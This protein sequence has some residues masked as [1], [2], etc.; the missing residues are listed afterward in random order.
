[1]SCIPTV[2]VFL[3]FFLALPLAAQCTYFL[4][5]NFQGVAKSG[6][7]LS[8]SLNTQSGCAWT[9]TTA[10]SWIS[11]TSATS[12][13]GS[14][15]V[16]YT[17]AANPNPTFRNGSLLIAGIRFA[18][19]QAGDETIG[20]LAGGYM[21]DGGQALQAALYD[22]SQV[23]VD[24]AG[25][26]YIADSGAYRVRKVTPGGVIT[27]I[28]GDGYS[29]FSGDGGLATSARFEQVGAIAVDA[30]GNIYVADRYRIR[31]ITPA[32]MISTYAGTGQR[33]YSGDGGQATAAQIS[34][35][36]GLAVSPAGELHIGDRENNRVRKVS[37]GGVI[38]TVAGNGLP[39]YF[40]PDEGALATS[41]GLYAPVG[42]AFDSLGRM[43]I[44]ESLGH[45]IRRVS[46]GTI[47]TLAGN[48][49]SG[50][51]G[52][53]GPGLSA[54]LSGPEGIAVDS[55]GSVYFSDNGTLIRKLTAAGIISTFTGQDGFLGDS[56]DG[57]PAA[58]AYLGYTHG[59]AVGPAD[60]IYVADGWNQ[61]V[62]VVD[63]SGNI[64]TVAGPGGYAGEG[65]PGSGATLSYP[66][67]IAVDGAGSAY[68][69]QCRFERVLKVSAAGV[70]TT[71]AGTGVNGF[72]GDGAP[73]TAARFS[74]PEAVAVDRFGAV[75]IGDRFN[76][77]IRKVALD[78]T[79]TTVAGGGA[80][81]D[82]SP[83]T[84]A[85]LGSVASIGIDP[86]GNLFIVEGNRVRKVNASGIIQAF[87]GTGTQ[88]FSGDGGPATAATLYSP[89][90]I[91]FDV[92][93]NVYISDRY[94]QRIRVVNAAGVIS[95]FA[96]TGNRGYRNDGGPATSAELDTPSQ[97]A[98]DA[99]GR[100]Y[101]TDQGGCCATPSGN[102]IRRV[103]A[104]GIIT[105]VVGAGSTGHSGDGGSPLLA[106]F[107]Y[108]QGTAVATSGRVFIAD[109]QN[110]RVRV[111]SPLFTPCVYNL[112]SNS[113][114][115]TAGGG[116]A[117]VTVTTSD[118]DC[119]SA[120]L[121]NDAWI[122]V[123]PGAVGGVGSRTI[124]YTV[125][126]NAGAPRSGSI[127]IAGQV[128]TV[129]QAAAT[130]CTYSLSPTTAP[131]AGGLINATV[132]T[133]VGCPW[134]VTGLPFWI[135]GG[136]SGTGPGS[137]AL[138]VAANPSPT[139]R[140]ATFQVGTAPITFQQAGT[141][142]V[143]TAPSPYQ[144]TLVAGGYPLGDG[145]PATQAVFRNPCGIAIDNDG[146]LIVTEWIGNRISRIAPNG[147]ITTLTD[148]LGQPILP[149][150]PCGISRDPAGNL[151]WNDSGGG[152]QR[153]IRRAPSGQLSVIA[154]G[155]STLGDGGPATSAQLFAVARHAFDASG[156][157]YLAD[158]DGHRIR[159]VTPAGIISTIAGTGVAGFSGD[160]GP[161]TSAQVNYPRGVAIDGAGN[162]YFSD[163]NNQRIRRITPSGIIS[164][165][166]GD[167]VQGN[168]GDGGPAVNAR[169]AGPDG[170]Y[171][172]ANGDLYVACIL[173]NVVRRISS[174]GVMSTFA[175]TGARGSDGDGGPAVNATLYLPEALT[176]DTAGNLY[177][178]EES[179]S[180]IRKVA[181]NGVISSVAGVSRTV[182]DGGAAVTSRLTQ[183][184][185]LSY[186]N[187]ELTFT[188]FRNYT[189][190]KIDAA[191]I[192]RIIGGTS[193]YGVGPDGPA[194]STD[195]WFPTAAVADS[196][197]NTF[198]A[199]ADR[200]ARISPSGT[201]TT[202]AAGL[203]TVEGMAMDASGNLYVTIPDQSVIRKIAPGGAVSVF[204]GNG[205][206]GFSGDGGQ[207]TSA[208]INIPRGL[209]VD[210]AGNV[211]FADSDNHRIRQIAPSG[212]ITTLV[213]SGSA[214]FS[215]DGGLATAAQL[216]YPSSVR[217]DAQ[218]RLFLAEL[219]NRRIRVVDGGFIFTVAGNGTA[220]P[221]GD[222]GAAL[223]AG[224]IPE[225][226]ELGANGEVYI[227]G[228]DRIRKLTY[229]TYNLTSTQLVATAHTATFS[230]ATAA[231]CTWN[232]AGLPAWITPVSGVSGT[233]PGTVQ[234]SIAAN[235]SATARA[236]S[237]FIGGN[238]TTITQAGA[239]PA[240]PAPG[241]GPVTPPPAP[242]VTPSLPSVSM[243]VP[244]S[245]TSQQAI[246]L[247]TSTPGQEVEVTLTQIVPGLTFSPSRLTLPGSVT[248]RINPVGVPPGFYSTTLRISGPGFNDLLIPVQYDVR[249]SATVFAPT[250]PV[251]L[252]PI[253]PGTASMT[254]P[255]T[256]DQPNAAYTAQ[257]R[258]LSGLTVSPASGTLPVT[259]TVNADTSGLAPGT[260]EATV[261]VTT[262][263]TQPAT[264]AI[265]IRFDVLPTGPPAFDSG[266]TYVPVL[267]NAANPSGTTTVPLRNLGLGELQ[268]TVTTS[269]STSKPWL[270]ARLG[271]N[272]IG[273]QPTALEIITDLRG[274]P[275]SNYRGTV[276]LKA[277]SG[278]TLDIPVFASV[279]D[280][281][282]EV[283]L[284][285][286]SM[287]FT[288]A[289][290]VGPLEQVLEVMNRTPADA[291][292]TARATQSVPGATWLTLG[293]SGGTTAADA[294][295]RVPIRADARN[296]AAGVYYGLVEV[297]FSRPAGIVKYV[298][299]VLEVQA[300]GQ[301]PRLKLS[302]TGFL[303]AGTEEGAN[304]A[305]QT[306]QITN[307]TERPLEL[308][309][310]TL[311]EGEA[312]WLSIS[313]GTLRIAAGQ[314][315]SLQLQSFLR[316]PLRAGLARGTYRGELVIASRE[317]GPLSRVALG[318][319][320]APA[321]AVPA[322]AKVRAAVSACA[323]SKYIL[324]SSQLEQG[325]RIAAGWPAW[326]EVLVL[327]DCGQ[328]LEQGVVLAAFGS[329]EDK[330][331]LKHAGSGRWVGSWNSH[332]ARASMSI[333]FLA[334]TSLPPIQG[335]LRLV[336]SVVANLQPP[337]I[338]SG[339]VTNAMR[340]LERAPLAP[341][342]FAGIVGERLADRASE[343][344]AGAFPAVLESS[345]V[346][347]GGRT[348]PLNS[349]AE[350]QV[351]ALLPF[352]LPPRTTHQVVVQRGGVYS[353][354]EA[355]TV[356]DAQP[357][358]L[359]ADNSGEG[360]GLVFGVSAG[361]PRMADARN[362]VK[363]GEAVTL[364]GFGLGA[365]TPEVE[366]GA[367]TPAEPLVRT[368]AKVTATV[369]G[370]PAEVTYSGLSPSY[371]GLY[372]VNLV[373]P[374]DAKPG[375]AVPL[376]I[377][378]AGLPSN[379][380]T[381]A[382]R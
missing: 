281:A 22:S 177:I 109:T 261:D 176:A 348:I 65:G 310:D 289:A 224:M 151:V 313:S 172:A 162:V 136:G 148:N 27:T 353:L 14:A 225:A 356:V 317:N 204:A 49:S 12:G 5:T 196:S 359:T 26:L 318:L 24:A 36:I 83:A 268:A 369:G 145:G 216:Y 282:Y 102:R 334:R 377:E 164:T 235:G 119:Q 229:C 80:G 241:P 160:G 354:P 304:P 51:G 68:I 121:S 380:V 346:L 143:P 274:F 364:Y 328:P 305:A 293:T 374:A 340:T 338:A 189:V 212:I 111:T 18:V 263:G 82:G 66:S 50:Y 363:A 276:H 264:R 150:G 112:G 208:E 115:A 242:V 329:G 197:G 300:A 7:A 279:A 104:S 325:F 228:N 72:S 175:G 166:A 205:S 29:G 52:D 269:Q 297:T 272:K 87:A 217:R 287:R 181:P 113:A 79:I 227:A 343:A 6:A 355:I 319:I 153:M 47:V 187:G 239:T 90:G 88:G 161:A 257:A 344:P 42:V 288:Q 149:I 168:S 206:R 285:H 101:I 135:T 1:M 159:K 141:V 91:A 214:G 89:E 170:L 252:A 280:Q 85:S 211:I 180:R 284:S 81:G 198:V 126:S 226:I 13:T 131:A 28:A 292:W 4:G 308:L 250:Q 210:S 116:L 173:G 306:L 84:A 59:V 267:L 360:Q 130:P 271:G 295:T 238:S 240:P 365:V 124:A 40:P 154:G 232:L 361:T 337:Q 265:P 193:L 10:D 117:S 11:I 190:R 48:G 331:E 370:V 291:T 73:A 38:S 107:H 249:A 258:G 185:Y 128:F 202:V 41:V 77:R 33:G 75:Y 156:N 15:T 349:V 169:L 378:A 209:D 184:R 201:L 333:D 222:G 120:A 256:S 255:V 200:V 152:A 114:N 298:V 46:G 351:R 237:V 286:S 231:G 371:I 215:G 335:T 188:E 381:L 39:L 315:A 167:G 139:Q 352:G 97:L 158:G 326:I 179:G 106:E 303:F 259:L 213:G 146:S 34:G 105:T 99:H 194:L 368:L 299:V 254:I 366:I 372:Q 311:L 35:F 207:A 357:A 157:L 163:N 55:G 336:G 199:H 312:R 70:V 192:I 275:A 62:K 93:G 21:G 183:P 19:N 247:T 58:S 30:A 95:T 67:Q 382:I 219:G 125:A 316:Q 234:A 358:I 138:N 32:G 17:I 245:V 23:A 182:G 25:N 100:L 296:L 221:T 56:A 147:I 165:V 155:G 60:L 186:R 244:P 9:V 16:L 122:T 127:W 290:G 8:F 54:Q 2:R 98:F 330:V 278:P 294:A 71:F 277:A 74:C 45:R 243:T 103:S 137:V 233:G 309:V 86:F 223:L 324:T 133:D 123:S 339:G 307:P 236:G 218:G 350:K 262:P 178:V 323:P 174:A 78:G 57:T 53:G 3:A 246:A 96:G 260:Y 301:P 321:A 342:T 283:F 270:T 191:G 134:T 220:A 20:T 31:R 118:T 341:G 63:L 108:P 230:V 345:R 373:I 129:N 376:V 347:V 251:S 322:A 144:I 248:V 367:P 203:G 332:G 375:A 110:R 76:G 69:P 302:Q 327:D 142:V 362:P 379:T 140:S 132:T 273:A 61:K 37:A 43:Y 94:N 44:A 64:N 171:L 266:S 253:G 314:T 320:V 195:I 92:L